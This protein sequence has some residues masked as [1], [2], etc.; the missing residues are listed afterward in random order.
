M[1]SKFSLL[2]TFNTIIQCLEDEQECRVEEVLNNMPVKEV[3]EIV[4]NTLSLID[5]VQN[6]RVKE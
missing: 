2:L 4:R 5:V 6:M 3:L 1:E